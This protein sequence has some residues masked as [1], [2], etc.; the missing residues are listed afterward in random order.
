VTAA[1]K[2]EAETA[3]V[4]TAFS[5]WARIWFGVSAVADGFT[6]DAG[7]CLGRDCAFDAWAVVVVR[8]DV[9]AVVGEGAGAETAVD[10]ELVR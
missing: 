8:D 1:F 10:A 3:L 6:V 2:I 9:T 7:A 4:L 5:P